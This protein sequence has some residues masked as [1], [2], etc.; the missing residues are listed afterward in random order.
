MPFALIKSFI[1]FSFILSLLSSITF[2]GVSAETSNDLIS[3]VC[4]KARN[5]RLCSQVLRSNRRARKASSPLELWEVSM[6]L[7]KSSAQATKNT[8]IMLSLRTRDREL[9][10]RYKSCVTSYDSAIY[11]LKIANHYWKGGDFAEVA[12]YTAAA[13]NEPISCRQN[14][15]RAAPA[16]PADLREGND[17]LEC[18]CSVVLII[19]N[20]LSGRHFSFLED[21]YKPKD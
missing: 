16:E 17:K 14:F 18:L 11:Y 21:E 20:R 12:R 13:L 10:E 1:L 9:R 19:S 3:D 4:R 15:A 2:P 7:S 5:P 6:D 8:I